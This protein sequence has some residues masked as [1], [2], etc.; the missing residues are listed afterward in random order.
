MG[1]PTPL[2]PAC[3]RTD[4]PFD[5]CPS[6]TSSKYAVR[7]VCSR[8]APSIAV[9]VCCTSP[10]R[11]GTRAG[12]RHREGS[13]DKVHQLCCIVVECPLFHVEVHA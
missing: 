1:I 9:K 11:G 10:V 5:S 12:E 6:M 13:I 7:K 2:A 3:M 4:C 8:H